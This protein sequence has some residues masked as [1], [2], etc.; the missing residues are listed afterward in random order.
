MFAACALV[1]GVLLVIIWACYGATH[2]EDV[3]GDDNT[4]VRVSEP[5]VTVGN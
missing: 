4:R 3:A 1:A 2:V 5:P